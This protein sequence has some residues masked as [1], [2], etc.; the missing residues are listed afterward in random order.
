MMAGDKD[1]A[2]L[3]PAIR[4]LPLS[5][6]A[7]DQQGF[8]RTPSPNIGA[9]VKRIAQNVAYEALRGNLPDEPRSTDR[10]GGQ[11]HVVIAK[12]LER[13][14]H[15]PQLTKFREYQLN[16]FDNPPIGMNYN[17]AGRILD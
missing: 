3:R 15:A 9:R 6:S 5:E 11:L 1:P 13:L 8:D 17:L 2:I 4:G 7:L 16:G 10:V 12:P 14:A